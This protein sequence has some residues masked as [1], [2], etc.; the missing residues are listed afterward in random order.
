MKKKYHQDLLNIISATFSTVSEPG[1]AA[2]LSGYLIR[3]I[4]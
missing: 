3:Q 1:C 4:I 2:G